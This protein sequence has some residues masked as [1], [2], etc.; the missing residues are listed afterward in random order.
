M[1]TP[2]IDEAVMF[3]AR[4]HHGQR[5]RYTNLPYLGH[6][7]EVME[8]VMSVPHTEAMLI[9]AVL[10]D[11][12]EDT[13]VTET[14]ISDAFGTEVAEMVMLLSDLEQ[15]NRATRKRL[16]RERLAAAPA[17]VQTVK[18]ADLISNTRTIVKYD[19]DF[20]VAYLREKRELLHV[21]LKG[22]PELFER[23][24]SSLNRDEA[25]LAEH[26]GRPFP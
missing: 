5:R 3:A 26:L 1:Y 15:G 13:D 16:A 20:A 22:E 25:A 14:D 24:V 9:A 12:V 18:L 7:L 6:C 21:L 17:A 2:A 23:A 11:T 8:L 10:H 19:K 4:A